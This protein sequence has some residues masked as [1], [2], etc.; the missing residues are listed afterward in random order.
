MAAAD[1][2]MPWAPE[3]RL[4]SE[5]FDPWVDVPDFWKVASS[6]EVIGKLYGSRVES[7]RYDVL[8]RDRNLIGSLD[9][10]LTGGQLEF[11]IFNE[12]KGSGSLTT[13]LYDKN[14]AAEHYPDDFDWLNIL[15][16]VW[17]VTPDYQA[18]L[19]TAVP[20]APTEAHTDTRVTMEVELYDRTIMLQEDS[21]GKPYTVPKGANILAAVADVVYSVGDNDFVYDRT[22]NALTLKSAMNWP[23][24]ASKFQIV[25]DLLDVANY[26]S[27]Y[28][29]AMGT[30][31]ADRYIDPDNRSRDFTFRYGELGL[32]LPDFKWTIDRY[33]IPNKYVLV[34][35]EVTVTP[36]KKKGQKKAPK[37]YKYTPYA[38]VTDNDPKSPFSYQARGNRYITVRDSNVELPEGNTEAQNMAFV[39][40]KA[41]QRLKEAQVVGVKVEEL[42]HPWLPFGINSQ[43]AF[44]NKRTDPILAV[45]QAQTIALQAGGLCTSTLRGLTSAEYDEETGV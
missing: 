45:C 24:S 28:T 38:V 4:T 31:R 16:R 35:T 29:D 33:H 1:H 3:S 11:N 25:N 10:A 43:V 34:G 32:Y 37:G 27:I 30:F 23:V 7:F 9:G 36:K 2:A 13:V 15:L 44:L 17:Y 8:D 22:G 41:K 18:A 14:Y 20:Q 42:R 26:T 19:I 12:V 39:L 40:A 5:D 6:P 21:F